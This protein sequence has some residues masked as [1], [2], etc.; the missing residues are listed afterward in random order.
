MY[1]LDTDVISELRKTNSGKADK[2]VIHWAHTVSV[3]ALYLSVI[4]ILELE[5]GI[6]QIERRDP[7]Q[8]DALR[9]WMNTQV[10]PV[11]AERILVIDITIAQHCALLHVPNSRSDRDAFIAATALVHDMTIVT[12]NIKDFN[13]TGVKLINP[14]KAQLS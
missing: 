2:N 13:S 10:L 1:L 11:F 14:W 9:Y 4:S 7:K 12:R 6:L 3:E 5:A 8:G